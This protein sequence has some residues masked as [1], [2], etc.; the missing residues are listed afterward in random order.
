[1]LAL[2]PYDADRS[3]VEVRTPESAGFRTGP[4]GSHAP[5]QPGVLGLTPSVML[6]TSC[7]MPDLNTLLADELAGL[8]A[9]G[10][11]RGLRPGRPTS[12]TEFQSGDR[13]YLN[14][15]SND[16]LGLASHP[17]VIEAATQATRQ[18]G[19]GSG[20]SRLI[21]GSLELHHG[22][23]DLITRWKGTEA[24]LAFS[25][26]YSTA[27]GV[28][29][30]LIGRSDVAVIDK[31]VHACCVDAARLSGAT[32]RV[33]RHND[34]DSL[35]SILRWA[36]Q[37]RTQGNPARILVVTESVFSMDGDQAPLEELV[38]L[39]DR[40][41]AWLLL[42]EAHATGLFGPNRSGLAS[43]KGLQGRVEIQMGTLGKALGSAGGYIAGSKVLIDFLVNKAR[44]FVFSTAPVPAASAAAQKSIEIIT[45]DEGTRRCA[46]AWQHAH[47]LAAHL[48][49][50]TAPASAI[51]PLILGPEQ[52]ALDA[53][54]RLQ[55]H[56]ILVP[57]I[58]FPTVARG[59][60]RLRITVSGAHHPDQLGQL[61]HALASVPRPNL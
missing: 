33:F 27:L 1:M 11:R 32:L 13:T 42:D 18:W 50:G 36:D 29:P 15:A 34:L 61:I 38:Q 59:T 2:K 6:G 12:S 43:A 58:R 30:A 5:M 39:K 25:S 60:A 37:R 57:A 10:L 21:T 56:G 24:A 53:S 8:D 52:S 49:P 3:P 23:E 9:A 45:S 55:Q 46:Q 22:L 16:Y 28:I 17:A 26:G 54:A 35:E 41:G 51:F 14:F 4:G 44:S 31:R 40:F 7:T 48:A 19:A 47:R 20:A